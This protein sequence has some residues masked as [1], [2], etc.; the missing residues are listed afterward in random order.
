MIDDPLIRDW[1][2]SSSKPETS[3]DFVAGVVH[4]IHAGRRRM[5]AAAVIC[6]FVGISMLWMGRAL[7]A[8]G[9]AVVSTVFSSVSSIMTW[10]LTWV[11]SAV[12]L[13]AAWSV[14]RC[15]GWDM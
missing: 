4:R 15:R 12:L 13:I 2:E 8:S 6:A 7:L 5:R 3:N 14:A 1:F 10:P 9:I 11:V